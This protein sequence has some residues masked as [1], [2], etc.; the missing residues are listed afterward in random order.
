LIS[1]RFTILHSSPAEAEDIFY[2]MD[3]QEDS[4]SYMEAEELYSRLHRSW[5]S[6]RLNQTSPN[7]TAANIAPVS[8]ELHFNSYPAE[9]ML[10]PLEYRKKDAFHR[11]YDEASNIQR[12]IDRSRSILESQR[13]QSIKRSSYV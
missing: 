9:S 11:L 4:L 8:K 7:D 13:Q 1:E 3:N 12:R 2:L 6:P 10:Y 5:S